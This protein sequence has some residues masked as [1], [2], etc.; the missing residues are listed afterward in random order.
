MNK[1]DY[2]KIDNMLDKYSPDE[3]ARILC[4]ELDRAGIPYTFDEDK[5]FKWE[6]LEPFVLTD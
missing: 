6:P 4:E 3:L 5:D 1:S 2:K